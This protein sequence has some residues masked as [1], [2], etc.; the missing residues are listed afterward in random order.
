MVTM[1][2]M[3]AC[4]DVLGMRALCSVSMPTACCMDASSALLFHCNLMGVRGRC[5]DGVWN[6]DQV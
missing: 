4:R 1:V 2:T 3:I 6:D 5:G